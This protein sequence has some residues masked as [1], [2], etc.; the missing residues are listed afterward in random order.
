MLKMDS[1]NYTLKHNILNLPNKKGERALVPLPYGEYQRSL[2]VDETLKRGS[3]TTTDSAV[4]IA[5]SK[6]TPA[7]EPLRRIGYDLN[8]KSIV[9]S[10]GAR[11]DLSEVARLHTQYGVRRSE[12]YERHPHDSRLKNK[13]AGSRRERERIK[14]ALS[15]VSKQIV[16]K[17]LKN[18]ESIVLERLKGIRKA[19]QKGNLKGRDSRRRASL[20][21]LRKLQQQIASRPAGRE[22]LWRSSILGTRRRSA[23]TTTTSTRS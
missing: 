20:W 11:F 2:L 1:A 14:Q 13:F 10:D 17:A 8:H 4:V 9:G 19:H 7:I 23:R 5:F 12:F 16:E 22:S 6:E 15:R 21:P 3:V 18:N